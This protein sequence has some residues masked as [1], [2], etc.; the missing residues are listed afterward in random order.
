MKYIT[1]VAATV[2]LSACAAGQS[3][4]YNCDPETNTAKERF[5]CGLVGNKGMNDEG[6]STQ[7]GSPEAPSPDHSDKGGDE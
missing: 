5:A 6:N 4:K 2:A 1:L 7:Y 3:S